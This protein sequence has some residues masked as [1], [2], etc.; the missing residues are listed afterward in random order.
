LDD[1][2]VPMERNQ[3]E[4]NRNQK[5]DGIRMPLESGL[6][7]SLRAA[8]AGGVTDRPLLVGEEERENSDNDSGAFTSHTPRSSRQPNVSRDRVLSPPNLAKERT[9]SSTNSLMWKLRLGIPQTQ[10]GVDQNERNMKYLHIPER[11]REQFQQFAKALKDKLSVEC[12]ESNPYVK[13]LCA[14]RQEM[15][16]SGL[17]LG[18]EAVDSL[19]A[20]LATERYDALASMQ[21]S[22]DLLREHQNCDIYCSRAHCETRHRWDMMELHLPEMEER[23]R[24]R[25]GGAHIP[26]MRDP[27]ASASDRSTTAASQRSELEARRVHISSHQGS[28]DQATLNLRI[29]RNR[30]ELLEDD[31]EDFLSALGCTLPGPRISTSPTPSNVSISREPVRALNGDISPSPRIECD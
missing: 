16:D 17:D 6:S 3:G 7:S 15:A 21:M 4:R 12:A 27:P 26:T 25:N 14:H 5:M 19:P 28:R 8:R 10:T 18:K 11:G 2:E 29:G 20:R 23:I 9:T 31:R 22:E 13:A 30:L 1:E 24:R